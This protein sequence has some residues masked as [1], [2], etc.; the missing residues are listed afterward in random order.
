MKGMQLLFL[1]HKCQ[2]YTRVDCCSASVPL[3][4]NF[5]SHHTTLKTIFNFFLNFQLSLNFKLFSETKHTLNSLTPREKKRKKMEVEFLRCTY[6]LWYTMP[7]V[8]SIYRRLYFA[9]LQLQFPYVQGHT[10]YAYS[11]NV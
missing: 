7:H 9:R 1:P 3:V 5:P 6:I 8:W 4:P 2:N 10:R 11:I